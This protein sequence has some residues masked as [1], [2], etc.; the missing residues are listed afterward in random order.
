MLKLDLNDKEGLISAVQ[1]H[2]L[3]LLERVDSL[4]D[5]VEKMSFDQKMTD[6]LKNEFYGLCREYIDKKKVLTSKF[7]YMEESLTK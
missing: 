5:R 3:A 1:K 7:K 6:T 2:N 4:A